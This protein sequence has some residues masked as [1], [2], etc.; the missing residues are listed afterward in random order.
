MKFLQCLNQLVSIVTFF[1][2]SQTFEHD[3][4]TS[5][6]PCTHFTS[7]NARNCMGTK[8]YNKFK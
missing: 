5:L 6:V 7:A 3:S 8:F 1:S 2:N 4:K